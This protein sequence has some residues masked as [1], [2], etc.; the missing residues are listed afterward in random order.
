M[1]TKTI[2][3]FQVL[4]IEMLLPLVVKQEV[5]QDHKTIIST[6][7]FLFYSSGLR[8]QFLRVFAVFIGA[9]E[10][11][12]RYVI[13]E[14]CKPKNITILSKYK[15]ESGVSPTKSYTCW[16]FIY[17]KCFVCNGNLNLIS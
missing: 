5:K 3:S 11:E 12:M 13:A 6:I 10:L 16:Y 4:T 8:H 1:L 9:L 17:I 15:D 7:M 2:V 14:N